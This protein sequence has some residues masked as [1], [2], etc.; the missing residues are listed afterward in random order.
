MSATEPAVS[1]IAATP[2]VATTY[3]ARE[4]EET[5]DI[6]FYRPLGYQIACAAWRLGF[7]PNV[8]TAADAFLGILAGHLFL[9]RGWVPAAGGIAL[10]VTSEAFDSADGQLARLS[11]QYSRLG[12]ILDGL[13]SNLVF[14]SIYLHLGIRIAPELGTLAAI[15]LILVAG[16]SHSMQCCVADYYRNAFL[17]MGGVG[18]GELDE[19]SLVEADYR[20]LSWSRDLGHKLMLRLYLNY[21]RQQ[22]MLTR[23]FRGL[24]R[25]AAASSPEAR[26]AWL[27]EAYRVM[28]RPLLKYYNILT[29]NTRMFVLGVAV[30]ADGPLL[31]L[32]FEIVF[33]NLLLVWVSSIQARNND[34]LLAEVRGARTSDYRSCEGFPCADDTTLLPDRNDGSAR[35]PPS[36]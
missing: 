28:N 25:E 16:V 26:P 30:C 3:K 2:G 36:L 13:A 22:E 20:A 29:T 23:S 24:Q 17:Y 5:L 27:A 10:L 31:Y 15:G 1:A 19:A 34:R 12:R 11:G 7:T 6:W 32:G 8:V 14:T 21:T 9:Y 4:V 35:L 33:L 18:R